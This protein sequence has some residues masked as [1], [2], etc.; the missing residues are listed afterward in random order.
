MSCAEAQLWKFFTY[1][2]LLSV[3]HLQRNSNVMETTKSTTS[4]WKALTSDDFLTCA[5]D[6]SSAHAQNNW[7][8]KVRLL[9]T[10][11]QSWYRPWLL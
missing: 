5:R 8:E 9:S 3:F 1:N 10:Y 6:T 7:A 11:Y 4:S 2:H